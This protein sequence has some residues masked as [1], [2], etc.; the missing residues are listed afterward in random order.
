MNKLIL[1]TLVG[2]RAHGLEVETSDWDYRGVYCTPTSEILKLGG[3]VDQTSWLEGDTD[4]TAY[5]LG[6]FLQ[7]ALKSNATVLEVLHGPEIE[8]TQE[9]KELKKLFPYLWSSHGVLDAFRGYSLNQ[10]KKFLED[11]D[12]RP[13][14]YAVAYIRV[15]LMGQQLLRHNILTINVNDLWKSIPDDTFSCLGYGIDLREIKRGM[16]SKGKI[17]DWA[18]HLEAELVKAYEANPNHNNNPDMV[19][20]WLLKVRRANW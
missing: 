18:Q 15:L 11:K 19:N 1:K 13:W 10:R 16:W 3:K 6:K 14:K 2:S 5:E 12:S 7:M 20:E 4:E 9:G 17:V 8:C